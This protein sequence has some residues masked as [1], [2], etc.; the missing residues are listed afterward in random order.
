MLSLTQ[1]TTPAATTVSVPAQSDDSSPRSVTLSELSVADVAIVL[2]AYN[3]SKYIPI[4]AEYE[5]SGRVLADIQSPFELKEFVD[6]SVFSRMLFTKITE[7]KS[8]GVPLERLK[9]L[10]QRTVLLRIEIARNKRDCDSKIDRSFQELLRNNFE[11]SFRFGY[12]SQ[13]TTFSKVV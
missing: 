6:K 10:D 13:I 9:T 12:Y 11:F 1:P 7:F 8:T 4:F 2:G 3:L 5:V